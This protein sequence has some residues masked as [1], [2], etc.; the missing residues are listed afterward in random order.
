[1]V[2]EKEWK[3]CL[4]GRPEGTTAASAAD[5]HNSTLRRVIGVG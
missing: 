2:E 5:E 4:R 3:F 1:V